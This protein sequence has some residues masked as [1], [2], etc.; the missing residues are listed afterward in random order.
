MD[1]IQNGASIIIQRDNYMRV[2]KLNMTKPFVNLGKESGNKPRTIDLSSIVDKH[3][4]SVFKMVPDEKKQQGWI[5]E[6][7]TDPK[8]LNDFYNGICCLKLTFT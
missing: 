1:T 7:L 6:V 2:H 8:E 3:F 5:L 4:E